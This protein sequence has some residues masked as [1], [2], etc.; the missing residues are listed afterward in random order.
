MTGRHELMNKGYFIRKREMP[1]HAMMLPGVIVLFIFSYLPMI[2][3]YIAFQRFNPA[4]GLFGAHPFI[5]LENFRY[6]FSIPTIW[7]VFFN[8]LGIAIA[9]IIIGTFVPIVV[10][11]LLNECRNPLFKRG[12]QTAIYFPYFISWIILAGILL[13]ILSPGSG[14]VNTMLGYFGIKPVYFLGDNRY[15]PATLVFSD[16]WRN[17]GYNSVVYLAAITGIDMELYEAAALDGAG[18]WKQTLHVTLPGMS[19]IIILMVVLNMGNLLNAGFEQ[20][21]NLYSAQVYESGDIIDT[22]V[23][24]LGLEQAKFG[25][26]TAVGLLKSAIS[27]ILISSSYYIAY[28]EFDSKIC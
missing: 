20:V 14:I 28:K 26:S 8:T 24:R 9:K 25:P 3:V 5:G 23:Y 16:V 17:F 22:L 11:L 1:L 10:A 2:G 18:R 15:F 27:L 12:I 13:D 19:T 21:F 4:R 6:I 7:R